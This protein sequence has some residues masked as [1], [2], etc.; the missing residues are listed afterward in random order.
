MKQELL[1]YLFDEGTGDRQAGAP[2]GTGM[3]LFIARKL[4][5]FHEGTITAESELGKGSVF[6]VAL[7]VARRS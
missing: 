7:P 1:A 5:E 6:S 3:G 2:P 4:T